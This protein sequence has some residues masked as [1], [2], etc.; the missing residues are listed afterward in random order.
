MDQILSSPNIDIQKVDRAKNEIYFQPITND[1]FKSISPKIEVVLKVTKSKLESS[2]PNILIKSPE[3]ELL[4]K[5]YKPLFVEESELKPNEQSSTIFDC[6]NFLHYVK[7][8]EELKAINSVKAVDQ[9]KLNSLFNSVKEKGTLIL[10]ADYI[11]LK[12]LPESL[13]KTLGNEYKTKLFLKLY[14]I[15]KSPFI[16]MLFI[17]KMSPSEKPIELD[18]EKL[19]AYEIYDDLTLTKPISYTMG[20]M[21]KSIT[22][23]Y[24]MYQYQ[25]YLQV[26][27]PG[28]IFPVQI[29]ENFYSDNIEC[30]LTVVDS[31]DQD[32]L[33]KK[34]CKA[35]IVGKSFNTEFMYLTNEGQVA[36][37]KQ[38]QASR[39]IIIRPSPFNYDSVYELKN[40]MNSYIV[41]FSFAESK[42]KQIPIML[43]NE[44]VENT[45]LAR[46]EGFIVID[47]CEKNRKENSRRLYFFLNPDEPECAIKLTLTSKAK[48]K[49]EQDKYLP[50][51]SEEKLTKKGLQFCFDDKTVCN[52]YD[53]TVLSLLLFSNLEQFPEKKLNILILGAGI[54]TIGYYINKIFK[55]KV[56]IDNVEKN[57]NITKIGKKYFAVNNYENKKS[58]IQ[59]HFEEAK[60]F[61]LDSK[62]EKYYDMIVMDIRNV[63]I[64]EG[65]SPNKEFFEEEVLKKISA[66]M[67]PKGMY[68]LNMMGRSYK[69]YYEAF[70]SL[71]KQ[72]GNIFLFENNED[73]NK[74]HFC[75]N[76]KN[77]EDY[78]KTLYENN[79]KKLS[80]SQNVDF[81][82]IGEDHKEILRRVYDTN[83]FKSV[84]EFNAKH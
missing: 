37:C 19:I 53:K 83:K 10:L 68:V 15:E 36:L 59:W 52:F 4:S 6:F 64:I 29:K 31:N 3:A 11:F 33:K 48:I 80:E 41:L 77:E 40:R 24:E 7:N 60:K 38:C 9:D 21:A 43:M 20:N 54:G 55:G 23:M 27:H 49:Q 28:Q 12:Q 65:L 50:L 2:K 32:I 13:K 75:Y 62:N 70:T 46:E 61:I 14:I 81:T 17:Q 18:N 76:E 16:G 45:Q 22:Y 51:Y 66:M 35:I 57:E 56:N 30:T 82:L 1:I 26:L 67:K 73:L 39:I 84:L 71:E 58:N 5:E 34:N 44:S 25:T 69:K 8:Q 79:V 72:F 42:D 47:S 74:I 63:D 78:F